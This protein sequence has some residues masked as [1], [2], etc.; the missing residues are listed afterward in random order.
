MCIY[1]NLKKLN[2]PKGDTPAVPFP[3]WAAY[4]TVH[5]FIDQ[6]HAANLVLHVLEDLEGTAGYHA[7]TVSIAAANEPLRWRD[8][9]PTICASMK[10][11]PVETLLEH[12]AIPSV[13]SAKNL[14]QMNKDDWNHAFTN[15]WKRLQPRKYPW[16]SLSEEGFA[17]FWLKLAQHRQDTNLDI[18]FLRDKGYFGSRTLQELCIA[19]RKSIDAMREHGLLPKEGSFSA[20]KKHFQATRQPRDAGGAP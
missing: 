6:D 3:E 10:C 20:E 9:W 19:V 8:I 5:S 11:D 18:N 17:A 16:P 14:V 4:D 15:D 1:V 13:D 12:E 7:A 2:T